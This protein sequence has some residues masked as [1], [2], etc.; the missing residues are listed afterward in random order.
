MTDQTTE[1]VRLYRVGPT[2]AESACLREGNGVSEWLAQATQKNGAD[3]AQGRWFTNDVEEANWYMRENPGYPIRFVDVSVQDIHGL[4]VAAHSKALQ[5]SRRPEYEFFLPTEM[6]NLARP[7]STERGAKTMDD[8]RETARA[9][10]REVQKILRRAETSPSYYG[11]ASGPVENIG[12]WDTAGQAMAVLSQ[13]PEATPLLA[14][15]GITFKNGWLHDPDGNTIWSYQLNPITV[16][17]DL[18][19]EVTVQGF[20]GRPDFKLTADVIECPGLRPEH[21]FMTVVKRDGEII[22]EMRTRNY[23]TMEEA[24]KMA[25]VL[26]RDKIDDHEYRIIPTLKQQTQDAPS[27]PQPGG[28][29]MHMRGGKSV[30][31]EVPDSPRI[32]WIDLALTIATRLPVI[33]EFADRQL[34]RRGFYAAEE[35]QAVYGPDAQRKNTQERAAVIKA[36]PDPDITQEQA[37]SAYWQKTMTDGAKEL[38]ARTPVHRYVHNPKHQPKP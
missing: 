37:V 2:P 17:P 21:R 29:E 18:P 8:A 5:F 24:L 36:M 9:Q 23:A 26:L 27:S 32:G 34:E 15:T 19:R 4:R 3:A 16:T 10:I 1:T 6:A 38:E 13:N 20:Y 30:T 7:L 31:T 33:G 35:F 11:D 22:H 28:G 14:E 12:P 25:P